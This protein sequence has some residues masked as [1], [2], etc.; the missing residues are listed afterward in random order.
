MGQW[1]GRPYGGGPQMPNYPP[2]RKKGGHTLWI[3]A[4]CA[5]AVAVVVIAA[6][7]VVVMMRKPGERPPATQAAQSPAA[8]TPARETPTA[9]SSTKQPDKPRAPEAP[10]PCDPGRERGPHC[11]PASTPGAAFLNRIE[12]AMKWRCYKSGEKDEAGLTIRDPECQA[13]NNVDQAYTKMVSLGYRTAPR[14]KG[15]PMQKVYI[16]AS[17]HAVN[18]GTTFKN[19]AKLGTHA[20]GIAV[21]HLWPGN[22][23]LQHEAKQALAKVQRACT[24]NKMIESVRLSSGYEITCGVPTPVVVDNR[25]GQPVLTIT[26]SLGI[27]VPFDY[28]MN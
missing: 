17:T 13:T 20:F 9:A 25:Q 14:Q 28:G 12:K 16:V 24:P 3:V 18:R 19:S 11:F 21:T 15:G 5:A 6:A 4:G 23:A 26:Q 27:G 10:V 1:N 8:E 22:K 7:A 2:A